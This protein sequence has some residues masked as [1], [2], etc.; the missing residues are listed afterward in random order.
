MAIPRVKHLVLVR[1]SGSDEQ[2]RR[3]RLA[4]LDEVALLS[5]PNSAPGDGKPAL[6]PKRA[7]LRNRQRQR[8]PD[9]AG[10]RPAPSD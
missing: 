10:S 8:K 5:P 9:D 7:P 6:G 4:R 3:Y 1:Y 2:I